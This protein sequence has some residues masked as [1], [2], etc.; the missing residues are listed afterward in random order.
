MT[1][2]RYC[3]PK[4]YNPLPAT[5]TT[6]TRFILKIQAYKY[7]HAQTRIEHGCVLHCQ[8][9]GRAGY[10]ALSITSRNQI[11]PLQISKQSSL[12]NCLNQ[13]F[14]IL[15][16]TALFWNSKERLLPA[17]Q[18]LEHKQ[19]WES[20]FGGIFWYLWSGWTKLECKGFISFYR[21]VC[22]GIYLERFSLYLA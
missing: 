6:T 1:Y 4:F 11:T 12:Y 14:I 15:L 8:G 20:K 9:N 21:I 16:I 5:I 13:L 10:L 22:M 17:V 2:A 18:T 19:E 7:P 3:F